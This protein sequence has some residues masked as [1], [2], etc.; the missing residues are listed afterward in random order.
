MFALLSF[1]T[2][3]ISEVNYATRLSEMKCDNYYCNLIPR[4]LWKNEKIYMT[5]F[6]SNLNDKSLN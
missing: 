2:I 4:G 1:Q 6:I 3:N 5:Y